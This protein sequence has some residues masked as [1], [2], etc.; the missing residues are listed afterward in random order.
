M[1][2]VAGRMII[3]LFPPGGLARNSFSNW[4]QMGSWYLNLTSGRFDAS[5]EIKAKVASS[6]ASSPTQLAKMRVLAE[7]MQHDI[8]YVGIELGIGGWQPHPA[9]EVFSHRYG[10]CKDKA[11]LMAAMLRE[12]GIDSDYVVIYT[13]R[14]SVTPRYA[15]ASRRF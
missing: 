11:T 14:G 7:F 13:E 10:D 6:T 1:D 15:G 12:I 9:A 3:T 5:P 2:G 4:Q 8:R